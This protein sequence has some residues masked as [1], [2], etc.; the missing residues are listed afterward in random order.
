M[1][2]NDLNMN[3]VAI[4]TPFPASIRPTDATTR[5][6]MAITCF[7]SSSVDCGDKAGHTCRPNS[8]AILQ[9]L[10]LEDNDNDVSFTFSWSSL[11]DDDGTEAG[12]VVVVVDDN[13]LV[14]KP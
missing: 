10:F 3:G 8:F 7:R 9:F 5:C 14:C 4:V 2:T 6:L 1:S 13:A 11:V 12:V